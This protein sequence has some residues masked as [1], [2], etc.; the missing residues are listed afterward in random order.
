VVDD[1]VATAL[2]LEDHVD[3]DLRIKDQLEEFAKASQILPQPFQDGNSSHSRRTEESKDNA[4]PPDFSL[5]ASAFRARPKWSPYGDNWDILW[6][7]H[8]GPSSPS[9]PHSAPTA[10]HLNASISPPQYGKSGERLVH[11]YGDGTRVMHQASG[12]TCTSAI[13]VTQAAARSILYQVRM[14]PFETALRQHCNGP[15][16]G[17]CV[18]VQPRL[19]TAFKPEGNLQNAKLS[20]RMNVEKLTSI[21]CSGAKGNCAH[22]IPE[23]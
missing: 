6:L 19:F 2:I 18:A 21:Q 15:R 1:G 7:G 5:D 12:N 20:A 17:A 9:R 22:I 23:G 4:S 11:E 14:A 13:G 16:A 3:W 8:C 10:F